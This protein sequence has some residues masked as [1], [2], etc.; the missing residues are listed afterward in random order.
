MKET[1]RHGVGYLHEALCS[2][3]QE[4]VTQL[5]EAERIQ[6]CVMSSSFCW[7]IPLTAHL[8]VVMGTQYYD[9]RE[10]SH[11]DYAVSDLLQMIGAC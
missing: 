6:I 10:N 7:R 5:F 4:I 9:G 11:A 3:D 2:L 8:V 1:L